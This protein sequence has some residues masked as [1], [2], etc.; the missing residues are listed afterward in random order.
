MQISKEL[1]AR[2]IEIHK[3]AFD[4]DVSPEEAAKGFCRLVDALRILHKDEFPER[5]DPSS[6]VGD[7]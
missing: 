7:N 6:C 1:L 5:F 2:Y 4:E 3:Y